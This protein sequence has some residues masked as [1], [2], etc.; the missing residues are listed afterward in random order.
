MLKNI[1]KRLRT[2]T[3]KTMQFQAYNLSYYIFPFWGSELISESHLLVKKCKRLLAYKI[4]ET[5]DQLFTMIKQKVF[6]GSF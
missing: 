5:V 3:Q 1:C 2:I 4:Y 6:I